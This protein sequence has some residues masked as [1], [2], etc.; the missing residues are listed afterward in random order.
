MHGLMECLVLLTEKKCIKHAGNFIIKFFWT[1]FCFHYNYVIFT[2]VTS[3]NDL[4]R[5]KGLVYAWM[6]LPSLQ[7][8]PLKKVVRDLSVYRD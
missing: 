6:K 3:L 4:V 1:I 2:Q 5:E 8:R 7:G